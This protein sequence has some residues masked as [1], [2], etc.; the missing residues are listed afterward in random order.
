M[1]ST[2]AHLHLPLQCHSAICWRKNDI[3]LPQRASLAG[4]RPALPRGRQHIRC[5]DL[6]GS[7]RHPRLASD[8]EFSFLGKAEA[9]RARCLRADL[10]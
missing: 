1:P 4:Q 7:A 10:V 9:A 2:G 3:R 5:F 8:G 6:N